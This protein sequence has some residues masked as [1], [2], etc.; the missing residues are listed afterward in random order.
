MNGETTAKSGTERRQKRAMKSPLPS[1][2]YRTIVVDP[3]WPMKFIRRRVRP[4]QVAMPYRVMTLD[5]I[6]GYPIGDL[7]HAAG[8]HLFLWT[9]QK[10]LPPAMRVMEAWGFRYV[11]CM[12]WH[13]PGGYQPGGLPQY[14]SE[15]VL[16]GRKGK[17]RFMTTKAFPTC[18]QAPRRG[19]S[20][21]P[22][23]FF[24]LVRRTCPAP[25]ISV[26]ERQI[27]P[28]FDVS[29]DEAPKAEEGSAR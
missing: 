2:S 8:S 14:N 18:F 11:L 26:F 1:G 16:Y 6:M 25:R 22:D 3:P 23:E 13:K 27:R 12:T 15:F 21:K 19:H 20:V 17:A 10:W 28:G 29:G 9:T 7:V 4:N 24:E 5:G